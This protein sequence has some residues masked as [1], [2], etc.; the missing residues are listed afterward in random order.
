MNYLNHFGL[1]LLFVF[2]S[3]RTS[4]QTEITQIPLDKSLGSQIEIMQFSADQGRTLLQLR[5]KKFCQYS[6]VTEGKLSESNTIALGMEYLFLDCIWDENDFNLFYR[7]KKND[8]IN[9]YKA[10]NQASSNRLEATNIESSGEKYLANLFYQG[11]FSV[12]K[13]SKTPFTLHEYSYEDD[14]YFEKSTQSFDNRKGEQFFHGQ[15][16]TDDELV[17]VRL[18]LNN[19]YALHFYRYFKNRGFEKRTV[20][21]RT[22]YEKAGFQTKVFP[23]IDNLDASIELSASI[24]G[25]GIYLDMEQL[26]DINPSMSKAVNLRQYPGILHLNWEDGNGEIISF[27]KDNRTDFVNRSVALSGSYYFKLLVS[28][29]FLDLSIY[30]VSSQKMLKNYIYNKDQL[31]D[32]IYEDARLSKTTNIN[33]DMGSGVSIPLGIDH[34]KEKIID[35]KELLKNLSDEGLFLDIYQDENLIELHATG[36]NQK[37]IILDRTL[38]ASFAAYLSKSDWSIIKNL[39]D[40]DDPNWMSVDEY[41]FNLTETN[42]DIGSIIVYEQQGNIYLAY[43]DKKQRLCKIITF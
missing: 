23:I 38:R 5:G 4:A 33:L 27:D 36:I 16:R 11:G 9:L 17:F 7:N 30:E 43:I 19:P 21:V 24:L 28:K 39:S 40:L 10:G 13:Y 8:K 20:D 3:F 37:A 2:Y 25:N 6:L 15:I 18:S 32:L 35:T 29:N 34:A 41:I 22:I 14:Q 26:V 42:K 1:I 12:F 31:I